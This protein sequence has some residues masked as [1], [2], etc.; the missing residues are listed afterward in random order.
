MKWDDSLQGRCGNQTLLDIFIAVFNMLLDIV[1][2]ILPMPVLWR[3]QMSKG[4][5]TA[6]NIIFGLGLL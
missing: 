3:L 2:V 4:R 5:K 6:S 1:V